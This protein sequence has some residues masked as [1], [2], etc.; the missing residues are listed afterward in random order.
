MKVRLFDKAVTTEL[1]KVLSTTFYGL[2][3]EWTKHVAQLCAES[4]VPFEAWSLWTQNYNAGYKRL[5][6]EQYMRPDLQDIPGKIGGHC[7]RENLIFLEP[8]DPF[9]D[10][11]RRRNG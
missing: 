11:I 5:H 10:L 2:C 9:A 6:Q 3:I 4:D 7:V 8:N 1:M